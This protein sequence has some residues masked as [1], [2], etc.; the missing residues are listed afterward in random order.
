MRGNSQSLLF[1]IFVIPPGNYD[2][3]SPRERRICCSIISLLRL[4]LATPALTV[5]TTVID[6]RKVALDSRKLLFDLSNSS[7]MPTI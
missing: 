3:P 1:D 2:F 7:R 5:S 6:L 4:T